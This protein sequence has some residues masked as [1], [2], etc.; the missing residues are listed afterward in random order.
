MKELIGKWIKAIL[1]VLAMSVSILCSI[2]HFQFNEG[3]LS[4][5][6]NIITIILA[7]I[8]CILYFI[9]N[10]EKKAPI[11]VTLIGLVA[12]S[13]YLTLS[14]EANF[15][16]ICI[17]CGGI[18]IVLSC[19]MEEIQTSVGTFVGKLLKFLTKAGFVAGIAYAIY[20]LFF[21]KG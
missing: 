4:L 1:F 15:Y 13:L 3:V 11:V 17:C 9:F 18:G 6:L 12:V 7:V 16:A 10:E 20:K 19:G 14:S 21:S 2:A 8:S 5:I